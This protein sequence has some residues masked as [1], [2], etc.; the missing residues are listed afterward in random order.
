[1]KL[2]INIDE[3][4]RIRIGNLHFIPE[5][6]KFK[7][8][9][10]IS[11]GISISDNVTNDDVLKAIFDERGYIAIHDRMC[12]TKWLFAPYQNCNKCAMNRS[13]DKYCDNC[14]KEKDNSN[15]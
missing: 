6:L 13:G 3:E 9:S 12:H 15:G 5:E 4:D 1:M 10:A 2:I 8:A 11:N 7:V 14:K